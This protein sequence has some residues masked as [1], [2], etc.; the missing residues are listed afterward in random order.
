MMFVRVLELDL[1]GGFIM[2]TGNDTYDGGVVS[3]PVHLF[4]GNFLALEVRP[5]WWFMQ[6]VKMISHYDLSLHYC[7]R[8]FT[9]HV[10]YKWIRGPLSSLDG[11]VLGLS[12]RF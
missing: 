10:G 12:C 9:F 8:F 7:I 3:V 1:G 4:I 2:M 6:G 11:F 5:E